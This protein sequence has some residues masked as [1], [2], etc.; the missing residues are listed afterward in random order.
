MVTVDDRDPLGMVVVAVVV[1]PA[2][3][4][5]AETKEKSEREIHKERKIIEEEI[6]I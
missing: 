3:H 5:C 6:M 2:E 4:V 1:V